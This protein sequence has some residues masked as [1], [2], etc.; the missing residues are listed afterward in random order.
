MQTLLSICAKTLL[1]TPVRMAVRMTVGGGIIH[2]R[3]IVHGS[4]GV[5]LD[6]FITLSPAQRANLSMFLLQK[7]Q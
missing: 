1:G 5:R 3:E 6:G 7:M 4:F 2:C